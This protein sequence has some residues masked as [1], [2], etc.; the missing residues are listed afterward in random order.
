MG[1]FALAIAMLTLLATACA[2]GTGAINSGS[3]GRSFPLP[4]SADGLPDSSANMV[5]TYGDAHPDEFAG[6]YFDQANGGRLVARFTGHLDEHQRALDALLGGPGRVVVLPAELTSA[7]LERIVKSLGNDYQKLNHQG[8]E[9]LTMAPDIIHNDVKVEAKSDS[10]DAKVT[11]EAYGPPGVVLVA[12]YP[13]DKAWT[14][15]TEGPGWRL[16]GAFDTHL[17][18]TVAF[19][20]DRPTLAADWKRYGMSGAPPAWEPSDEVA[21]IL[22]DGRGSTCPELRLDGIGIDLSARLVFG[23]FSD[24]LAPRVCTAD[25]KG[26]KTFVVAV[27]KNVLPPSP[28]TLRLHKDLIGCEPDCGFGPATLQVTLP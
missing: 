19:A 27:R 18:Y 9:L 7:T 16:L 21:L 13:A 24:P 12:L 25:L 20:L 4:A 3:P 28:F 2:S 26:A 22:S 11:L 15:P 17:P 23:Q 1:R 14:Q 8:I 5:Q 6:V 10:P